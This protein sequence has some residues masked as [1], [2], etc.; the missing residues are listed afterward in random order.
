MAQR[1]Q[2]HHPIDHRNQVGVS[3][4]LTIKVKVVKEVLF[5]R[6]HGCRIEERDTDD[7]WF[8][9]HLGNICSRS[10]QDLE[11]VKVRLF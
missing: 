8:S 7:S 10:I 3:L 11:V 2:G 4:V 9:K 1:V 5:E 6:I